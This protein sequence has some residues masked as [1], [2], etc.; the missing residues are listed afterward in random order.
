MRQTTK[1]FGDVLQVGAEIFDDL[2][3]HVFSVG[4]WAPAPGTSRRIL[5][6]DH[7]Y[8]CVHSVEPN[9]IEARLHLLEAMD[10]WDQRLFQGVG[11]RA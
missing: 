7:L 5:I 4:W 3:G 11:R 2:D 9:L 10:C 8:N 1:C 6:S